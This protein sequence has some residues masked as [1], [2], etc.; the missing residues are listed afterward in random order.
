MLYF[1]Q[2]TFVA[3]MFAIDTGC[4][5]PLLF[6]TVIITRGMFDGP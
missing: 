3:R 1:V 5:P 2:I 6:V 4:P